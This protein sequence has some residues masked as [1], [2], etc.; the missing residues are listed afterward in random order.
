MFLFEVKCL[1]WSAMEIEFFELHFL[2]PV[3]GGHPVLSSHLAIFRGWLLN[4]DLTL[5]FVLSDG[6]T[7]RVLQ[8]WHNNKAFAGISVCD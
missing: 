5:L 8:N 1:I 4:T 6:S 2:Q 7:V 3:L